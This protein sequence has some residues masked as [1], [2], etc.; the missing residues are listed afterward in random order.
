[1]DIHESDVT[2][3]LCQRCA[4]CC[5]I[6]LKIPESNSRY[7]RFLRTIGLEVSPAVDAGGLD[8][9]DREH[10]IRVDLGHCMHLEQVGDLLQGSRFACRIYG[11]AEYPQLCADFNCVSWAKVN[12]AYGPEHKTIAA[13]QRALDAL[14]MGTESDVDPSGI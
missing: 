3:E 12:D 11:S 9:C 8:C 6:C 1:M 10:G 14:R 7:R 4:V 2:S 13:A 5:N